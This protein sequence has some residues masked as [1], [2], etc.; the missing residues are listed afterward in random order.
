MVCEGSG[1]KA[2][3]RGR[4]ESLAT[5]YRKDFLGLVGWQRLIS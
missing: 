4:D 5:S 3:K 1:G 2:K